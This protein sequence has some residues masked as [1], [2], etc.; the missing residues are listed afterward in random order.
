MMSPS[1]V[2]QGRPGT[3]YNSTDKWLFLL[4]LHCFCSGRFHWLAHF[5]GNVLSLQAKGVAWELAC[6]SINIFKTQ[7]LS[8]GFFHVVNAQDTGLIL[9]MTDVILSN[10]SEE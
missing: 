5:S 6:T 8:S 2:K 10:S 7:D 4:A 1:E 3:S 9:F